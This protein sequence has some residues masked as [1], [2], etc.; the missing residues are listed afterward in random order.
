[1][2]LTARAAARIMLTMTYH[3]HLQQQQRRS[4][5]DQAHPITGHRAA[6]QSPTEITLQKD[7]A[8]TPRYTRPATEPV[9]YTVEDTHMHAVQRPLNGQL[10]RAVCSQDVAAVSQALEDGADAAAVNEHGVPAIL[11]VYSSHTSTRGQTMSS[12]NGY[13]ITTS[14]SVESVCFAVAENMHNLDQVADRLQVLQLLL[15]N[16]A[17]AYASCANGATAVHLAAA[18]GLADH[19]GCLLDA[20]G[21]PEI[22]SNAASS[23]SSNSSSQYQL[24]AMT[25]T[26]SMVTEDGKMVPPLTLAA[27]RGATECLKLL[28]THGHLAAVCAVAEEDKSRVVLQPLFNAAMVSSLRTCNAAAKESCCWTG[29]MYV[30]QACIASPHGSLSAS[31]AA[32]DTGATGGGSCRCVPD[33]VCVPQQHLHALVSVRYLQAASKLLKLH[34]G[35]LHAGM[36]LQEWQPRSVELLLAAGADAQQVYDEQ[37]ALHA[38]VTTIGD[39]YEVT[40]VQWSRHMLTCSSHPVHK[41]KRMQSSHVAFSQ[42]TA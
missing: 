32:Q 19:L 17:S 5:R 37:T 16:G 8:Y 14:Q 25:Y 6:F 2:D 15:A 23:S 24:S 41:H 20:S 11:L 9:S 21:P 22:M 40:A 35:E 29:L 33:P 34:H 1:M 42:A 39:E 18:A 28:L 4:L 26:R 38:A 3:R 12:S 30:R 31:G 36:L 7:P 10:L 27:T 13:A